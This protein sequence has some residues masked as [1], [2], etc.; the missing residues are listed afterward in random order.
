MFWHKL[1]HLLCLFAVLGNAAP[2]TPLEGDVQG[3]ENITAHNF[4]K[5]AAYQHIKH[6]WRADAR[7]PSVIVGAMGFKTKAYT[8]NL[9]DDLSLYRHCLGGGGISRDNDGY[10]STTRLQDV[11]DWW[12]RNKSGGNGWIYAIALDD[13]LIDVAATLGRYSPFP[14]EYEFAAMQGV[15]LS[16]IMGWIPYWRNKYGKVVTGDYEDN[17]YYLK[18]A[19]KSPLRHSE[20]TNC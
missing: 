4:E 17:Q 15:P 18:A 11:A 12:I 1:F 2:I 3:F 9:R 6:V 8:N 13:N 5:R 20:R 7:A 10:V 19:C 16:Q 14:K